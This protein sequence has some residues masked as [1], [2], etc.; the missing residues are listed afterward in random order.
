MAPRVWPWLL[1]GPAGPSLT[2]SQSLPA[3]ACGAA[4]DS[5][6]VHRHMPELKPESQQ[7]AVSC[8]EEGARGRVTD[9]TSQAHR[10]LVWCLDNAE[11]VQL[12]AEG[13]LVYNMLMASYSAND[14]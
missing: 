14:P 11:L 9:H 3:G 1:A 12:G 2:A 8:A 5:L 10:D 7:L 4:N 6:L 13:A